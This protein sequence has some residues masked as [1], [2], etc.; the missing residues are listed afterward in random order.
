ML[1][2]KINGKDFQ[3]PE[4]STI[5]EVAK[6]NG[7][8]IPTLCHFKINDEG[9]C[10]HPVGCRVCVVEV[11]KGDGSVLLPACDQTIAE[12]MEIVTDSQKSINARRTVVEL[13]M[14]NHPNDCLYCTRN[15]KCELQDL[16]SEFNVTG[17]RFIGKMSSHGKDVSNRS[18][19]KDLDK[20]IV[21]RRCETVCN[22]M[23]TVN[24][25]SAIN[26]GFDTVIS[27]AFGN[28][29]GDTP[30]TF[31]GQCVSVCPT[32]ALTEVS[33]IDHVWTA[34]NDPEQVVVVQP[35]PATRMA[36]AEEF[37][38]PAGTIATG[39]MVSAMRR[40]GFDYI[41]DVNWG[42]D[43]TIM[44]EA[45][46]VAERI[47]HGKGTLP[48][49]TSCCPAWINFIEY[50]FPKLIDIP[51][52]CKSPHQ[53]SG[54]MVKSYWAQKM[55]IDPA[56]IKVVSIMPCVAKKYE[57]A[58]DELSVDGHLDVDYVLTTRE[59]AQMIK[60][61]GVNFMELE[62]E[63]FDALLG[64]STGAGTIFGSTGGVLEAALRTAAAW[65][66]ETPPTNI[67]YTQVRGFDGIKEATVHIG[68]IDMHVAACSGLG[69]ARK[70]LEQVESGENPYHVIEI[71]ACPG[72]CING[73]GQPYDN[74]D[75][76]V[77]EARMKSMYEIDKN[78]PI[79]LSHENPEI[80]AL[81][82]DFLGKPGSDVA[83]KYL[84][85]HYISRDINEKIIK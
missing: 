38:A 1:N 46:E 61:A 70:L 30:C 22:Q 85:T 79:R 51:S 76:T 5:L 53:M 58:R 48:I 50:Q 32:A 10:N 67:E 52:T 45:T 2:V 17:Q 84:H 3:A 15:K 60:E 72:G 35:A 25:Y 47:L 27:P 18:I 26:R 20:C 21:C 29:F 55:N 28:K 66:D 6:E 73:G 49:L 14:S 7:Y 54:A 63:N 83:H 62:D 41:F 42:A 75:H 23:Q 77:I 68:G 59:L 44:E 8:H 82:N 71:M 39:K 36:I 57:S 11:K 4:G 64:E 78:K 19:V 33:E 16:A 12:G 37:G 81:Y 74:G 80:I 43:L 56:K 13:I 69:N 65:L 24:I 9:L 31:C 34:L 40:I